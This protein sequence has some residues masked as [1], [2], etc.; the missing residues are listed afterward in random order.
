MW[1]AFAVLDGKVPYVITTGN[2]DYADRSKR[3]TKLNSDFR[4]R[5]RIR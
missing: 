2:H 1:R 5:G 4:R 3:V